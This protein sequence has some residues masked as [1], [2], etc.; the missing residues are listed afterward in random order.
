MK[1]KGFRGRIQGQCSDIIDIIS[2]VTGLNLVIDT[3]FGELVIIIEGFGPNISLQDSLDQ[4]YILIVGDS[5]TIVDLSS[6]IVQDFV[7]NVIIF[8]QEKLELSLADSEIF[9][10][11]LVGDVPADGSELSSVL[12]DS[13]E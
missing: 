3:R 11:K 2:L 10:G 5:A 1:T 9:V 8:V 7:G 12:N 4:S 13:V 6:Q